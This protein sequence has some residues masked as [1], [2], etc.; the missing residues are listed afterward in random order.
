MKANSTTMFST[1]PRPTGIYVIA[2]VSLVLA[3][4]L[5]GGAY[6]QLA[7]AHQ[8]GSL[9][10]PFVYVDL[11]A[12]IGLAVVGF[13]LF[14]G[15]RVFRRIARVFFYALALYQAMLS[16]LVL[17]REL[18]AASIYGLVLALILL[19]FLIGARGYLNADVAQRFFDDRSDK[20]KT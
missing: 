19:L 12:A 11:A 16:F 20:N 6:L 7:A 2:G 18:N 10:G 14:F 8:A 13:G 4:L 15:V 17:T 5:G 9:Y 3:L 1:L